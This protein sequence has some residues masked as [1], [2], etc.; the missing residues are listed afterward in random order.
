MDVVFSMCL[1]QQQYRY[2]RYGKFEDVFN[3]LNP[4]LADW[5][6]DDASDEE[7]A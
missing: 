3:Q 2:R 1:V 7:V 6:V 4:E 5:S